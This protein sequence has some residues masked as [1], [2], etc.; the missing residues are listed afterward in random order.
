MPDE[1]EQARREH[2]GL[3]AFEE[4][5]LRLRT[6]TVSFSQCIISAAVEVGV[7][8]DPVIVAVVVRC[9]LFEEK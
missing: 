2:S 8:W 9:E 6:S 3:D 1:S 4:W 7:D 5:S